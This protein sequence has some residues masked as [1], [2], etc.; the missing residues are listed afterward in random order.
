MRLGEACSLSK[1]RT[2]REDW[3]ADC[4]AW[5]VRFR[6]VTPTGIT[7]QPGFRTFV[8]RAY[9]P[10][11]RPLLPETVLLT[12]DAHDPASIG[13]K[14]A[15]VSEIPLHAQPAYYSGELLGI[16]SRDVSVVLPVWPLYWLA[17]AEGH[18]AVQDAVSG[19][20]LNVGRAHGI[21]VPLPPLPEQQR[22][23]AAL[24][25]QMT[26]VDR[27]RAAAE[28]QVGAAR[29]LPAAYLREV[30]ESEQARGWQ[31]KRIEDFAETCSGSTPSRSRSDYYGGDIPWVKTGE[32]R[33][34]T[35]VDTEEHVTRSAVDSWGLRLLPAGTLLVAMYGQGQTRGRTALLAANATINQAC[36]AILPRP[37]D[38]DTRYLQLW[39]QYS[40]E[41]LR[42][43]TEGRGGSQPNLNGLFLRRLTVP[44][45]PVAAQREL[46]AALT[47][48]ITLA[49][50]LRERVQ[51]QHAMLDIVP[52]SLLHRA[53]RGEL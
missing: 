37:D 19:V 12:A 21:P 25:D 16:R 46:A 22:I 52:S 39:F 4:G 40:Y 41:R 32:L 3:Y 36:F 34:G 13:R 11:L 15:F 5:L 14:F 29:A 28:E 38:F 45:P 47:E 33:D 53:F 10:E 18:R 26:A 49:R 35:I 20:H 50:N 24:Q 2:P 7:W 6:D 30:F 48:R 1:G 31:K 43:E 27:A 23:A 51:E 44:L 42:R 8:S 9:E 17:S